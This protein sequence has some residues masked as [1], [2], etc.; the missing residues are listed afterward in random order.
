VVEGPAL[1]EG[2]AQVDER[3]GGGDAA[4]GDG[5]HARRPVVR[6]EEGGAHVRVEEVEDRAGEG[7]QGGGRDGG[8]VDDLEGRG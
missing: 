5:P 4:A 2:H 1:A 3:V 8:D 7:G 6:A